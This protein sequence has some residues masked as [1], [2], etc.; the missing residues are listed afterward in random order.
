[1]LVT[2]QNSEL[3]SKLVALADGNID[4]VQHAIRTASADGKPAE[5]EK[6][7]DFI[8]KQ[9]KSGTGVKAVA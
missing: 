3:I 5:L 2:M 1:M 4:L 6:V 8:V 7:V 9:R